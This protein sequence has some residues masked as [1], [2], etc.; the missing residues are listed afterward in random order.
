MKKGFTL[1]ELIVVIAVLGV[2]A[3]VLLVA[4]NPSERINEAYDAGNKSDVSQV[5]TALESYFTTNKGTFLK[6]GNPITENDLTIEGYI[7]R[8]PQS[9]SVDFSSD[10]LFAIAF[11]TLQGA[12]AQCN[13]G[14]GSTKYWVYYSPTGV[15]QIEC[16]DTFP[17]L[18]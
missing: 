7:K 12:S 10:G 14:S 16:L 4:I 6:N 13:T 5:S 3:S 18:P 2:L 15:S 17:D 1:I 11:S 8:F 9:V